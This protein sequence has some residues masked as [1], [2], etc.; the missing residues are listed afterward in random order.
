M[1]RRKIIQPIETA[2]APATPT[3]SVEQAIRRGSIVDVSPHI[4]AGLAVDQSH[5]D[6]AEKHGQFAMADFLRKMVLI[7][8]E[9]VVLTAEA[10]AAMRSAKRRTR[11][12]L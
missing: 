3:V 5:I 11:A 10:E 4:R 7:A 12:R 6:L 9:T 2:L 1:A 8:Y